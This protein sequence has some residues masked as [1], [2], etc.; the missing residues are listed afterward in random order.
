MK[1]RKPKDLILK[2]LEG[3]RGKRK[4]SEPVEIPTDYPSQPKH[5]RG[6]YAET[7]G[8]AKVVLQDNGYP[9]RSSDVCSLEDLVTCIVRVRHLEAEVGSAVIVEG[10]KGRRKN[11]AL[12]VLREYRSAM[13]RGFERFG[14]NPVDARHSRQR[15]PQSQQD[16]A[17][18][19]HGRVRRMAPQAGR[20]RQEGI[21]W[22]VVSAFLS[23]RR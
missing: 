15:P 12:Q 4:Q 16:A 7:W 1:G 23:D 14:L 5:F 3:N 20:S 11:P 8:A 10:T 22:R 2:V 17:H 13:W 18:E 6:E 9:V 19:G 21:M